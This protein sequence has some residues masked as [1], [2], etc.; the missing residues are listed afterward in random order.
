MSSDQSHQ[1][2]WLVT[3][4]SRGIGAAIAARAKEQ[5]CCVAIVAR[6]EEAVS[7]AGRLGAGVIAI[8]ADVSDVAAAQRAVEETIETFG[9]IDVVVNNAGVHR[10]GKVERLSPEDWQTVLNVNL[11]GA[12]N[13]IRAAK[14]HL[15][16]GSSIINIGAVVRHMSGDVPVAECFAKDGNDCAAFAQCGLRGPLYEA[17]QAFFGVLD[18]YNLD[19]VIKDRH[20]LAGLLA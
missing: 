19:Q 17:Q 2:V 20:L 11:T 4:A 9:R 5:G 15:Q 10:G 1:S 13:M 16:P 6:G 8:Q 12:L 18:Q 14:P 7:T 3:G